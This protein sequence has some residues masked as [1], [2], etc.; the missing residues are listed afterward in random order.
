MSTLNPKKLIKMSPFQ[1]TALLKSSVNSHDFGPVEVCR[2]VSVLAAF[3]SLG[4]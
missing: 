3:L 1:V 2:A 4:V